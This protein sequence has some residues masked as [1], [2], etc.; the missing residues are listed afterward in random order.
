MDPKHERTQGGMQKGLA[1]LNTQNHELQLAATGQ[2]G[3]RGS[4]VH[5]IVHISANVQLFMSSGPGLTILGYS[6]EL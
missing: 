6:N 2:K 4:R 1:N 5:R 3:T